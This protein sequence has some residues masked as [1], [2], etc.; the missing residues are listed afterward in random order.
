M[1]LIDNELLID[2]RCCRYCLS[3]DNITDLISPCKCKGSSEFVH[4]DCLKKWLKNKNERPVIPAYF[5][6][7][8]Y[9]CEVC[10]TEYDIEYKREP[11]GERVWFEIMFYI[12]IISSFLTL[13]Y[14]LTGLFIEEFIGFLFTVGNRWENIFANG[15]ITSHFFI[16]CFY[17]LSF[18][19]MSRNSCNCCLILDCEGDGTMA[20]NDRTFCCML[21]TI[22]ILGTF[23]IIYF[24]IIARIIQRARNRAKYI[25]TIKPYNQL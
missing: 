11:L 10:N 23:L 14:I 5:T 9:S 6:Q 7:F 15:F 24:D 20:V 25:I 1:S 12:F 17:L 19:C 21:I 22:S 16:G 13:Y 8:N 4:S 3:T 2:I 18:I